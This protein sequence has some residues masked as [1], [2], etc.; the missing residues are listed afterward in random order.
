MC[1]NARN[2]TVSKGKIC[3]RERER[4]RQRER[5]SKRKEKR[6]SKRKE[7]REKPKIFLACVKNVRL[8]WPY[9]SKA[10]RGVDSLVI[11]AIH[12]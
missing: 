12:R 8:H 2:H 7:K 9:L 4:I 1:P 5:E 10:A 11:R 3:E 6:E